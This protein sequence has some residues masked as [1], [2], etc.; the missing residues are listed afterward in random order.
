[1]IYKFQRKATGDVLMLGPGGDEV[2]RTMGIA[3]TTQGII[4]LAT[5][6]AAIKAL[7]PAVARDNAARDPSGPAAREGA[8]PPDDGGVTLRQSAWPLAEMIK[9]AQAAREPIVWGV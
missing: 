1:M 2:L 6:A 5:M 4:E 9:R 7:E 3:P 8:A